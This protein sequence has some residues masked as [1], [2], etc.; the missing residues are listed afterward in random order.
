ME[1]SKYQ[2][3]S[4]KKMLVGLV[5]PAV[6]YIMR[7]LFKDSNLVSKTSLGTFVLTKAKNNLLV[8]LDDCAFF[9]I[10]CLTTSV[11]CLPDT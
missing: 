2:S 10:W 8:G 9:C 6:E 4:E 5:E 1:K 3:L 11:I 7:C